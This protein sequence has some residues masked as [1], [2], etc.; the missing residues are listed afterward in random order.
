[1]SDLL[2]KAL[3]AQAMQPQQSQ[4]QVAQPIND[5]QLI[6]LIAAMHPALLVPE[7]VNRAVELVAEAVTQHPKLSE[8]IQQRRAAAAVVV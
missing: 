1:M 4:I 6:A 7:A 5:I 3:A 2:H 8:K